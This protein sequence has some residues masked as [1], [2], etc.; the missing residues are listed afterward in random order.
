LLAVPKKTSATTAS[1]SAFVDAHYRSTVV[2]VIFI[3]DPST[4]AK[5]TGVVN[6]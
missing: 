2:P 3:V 4:G 5:A 1:P 6:A